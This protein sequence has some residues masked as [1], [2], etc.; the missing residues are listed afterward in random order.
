[1]ILVKRLFIEDPG[2]EPNRIAKSVESQDM[3]RNCFT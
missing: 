1:M 2:G 3:G